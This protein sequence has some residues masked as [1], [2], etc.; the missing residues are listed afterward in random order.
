M[1]REVL[2][3]MRCQTKEELFDALSYQL[4]N[5]SGINEKGNKSTAYD[6]KRIIRNITKINFYDS[7]G[8]RHNLFDRRTAIKMVLLKIREDT[9]HI[10]YIY[11]RK[12]DEFI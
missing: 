3:S 1:L 8:N 9:S 5:V 11:R 7:E 6:Y 12:Q 4:D 2:V 10:E